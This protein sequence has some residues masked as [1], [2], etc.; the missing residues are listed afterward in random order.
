MKT[1]GKEEG[2]RP[3]V[4][5]GNRPSARRRRAVA[6]FAPV[7]AVLLLQC[8]D[9]RRAVRLGPSR[10]ASSPLFVLLAPFFVELA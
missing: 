2:R 10:K 6:N 1:R 8:S 4:V 5:P 9:A 3:A 7:L